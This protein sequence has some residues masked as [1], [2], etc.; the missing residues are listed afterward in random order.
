MTMW[1]RTAPGHEIGEQTRQPRRAQPQHGPTASLRVATSCTLRMCLFSRNSC[2]HLNWQFCSWQRNSALSDVMCLLRSCRSRSR[3]DLKLSTHATC[4]SLCRELCPCV[5][6][7]IYPCREWCEFASQY[8]N[9]IMP[10]V[11][12]AFRCDTLI[13]KASI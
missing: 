7:Y 6:Q 12:Y 1:L 11:A 2:L 4:T 10:R 3:S 5:R 8:M 9:V 13:H